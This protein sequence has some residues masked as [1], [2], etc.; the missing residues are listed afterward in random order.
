MYTFTQAQCYVPHIALPGGIP[1]VLASASPRRR[2]LCAQ[3]GLTFAVCPADCDERSDP[4]LLPL[5]AVE[6]LA[7]RKCE[8]AGREQSQKTLIIASDTMVELDG[9]PLGKPKDAEDAKRML[10]MLSGHRHFVRTGAAVSFGGKLLHTAASTAVTFRP[11]SEVEIAD[12]VASGEPMDKAGA[13]A[14][15][16]AG[17]HF[18]V[19]VCGQRDTVVG[20]CCTELAQLIVRLLPEAVID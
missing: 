19:E 12:Y 17:G 5:A 2:E 9:R 11:L 1:V 18:A 10:G 13:Y 14:I 20:L 7:T 15:Q 6:L 3:M 16:G 4:A 8:A